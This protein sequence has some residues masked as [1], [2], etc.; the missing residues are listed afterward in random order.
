MRSAL[1][2]LGI[3]VAGLACSS[4]VPTGTQPSPPLRSLAAAGNSGCYVVAGT[5]SETG[6]FPYFTGTIT[7]D[8]V[9]SSFTILSLDTYFTGPVG[10]VPG[11]RTLAITGG[12]IPQLIGTT[13]HEVFNGLTIDEAHPLIRINERTRID[14]GATSGNLT[15]HG[16]LNVGTFPWQVELQYQGVICP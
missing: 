7:G 9:G 13:V 3:A 12:S 16:T 5:I 1:L 4:E 11:D 15:T 10:H 14:A 6:A 8:L 2:T